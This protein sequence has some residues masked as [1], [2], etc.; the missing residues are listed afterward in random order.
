MGLEARDYFLED[1]V[2]KQ[3]LG[4]LCDDST[5]TSKRHQQDPPASGWSYLDPAMDPPGILSG[6]VLP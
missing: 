4:K 6:T 2:F 3:G 1:T 5:Q